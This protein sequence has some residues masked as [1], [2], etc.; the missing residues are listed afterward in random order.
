MK[1]NISATFVPCCEKTLIYP[2]SL[3]YISKFI[4]RFF[5]SSIIML[6]LRALKL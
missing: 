4:T 6:T 3:Q 2:D 1:G 5:V